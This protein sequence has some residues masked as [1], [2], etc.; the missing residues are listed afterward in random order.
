MR[1]GCPRQSSPS[2][3]ANPSLIP[4]ATMLDEI[5]QHVD[6]IFVVVVG[7]T[8]G[9]YRRRCFL[10]VAAAER[11]ANRARAAGHNCTVYL[12]ELRPLWKLAGGTVTP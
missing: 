6:G 2:Q 4:L 9:R 12:A 8:S 1:R 5:A 3:I 11:H 7:T 10:T